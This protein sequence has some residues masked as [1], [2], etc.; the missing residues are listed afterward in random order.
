MKILFKNILRSFLKNKFQ[1]II[2]MILLVFGGFYFSLFCNTIMPITKAYS[3]DKVTSNIEQFRFYPTIEIPNQDMFDIAQKYNISQADLKSLSLEDLAA[4]YNIDT[5]S[6]SEENI[7]DLADNYKFSYEKYPYKLLTT[8]NKFYQITYY[9]GNINKN[10]FVEGNAP[11]QDEDIAI[12]VGFANENNI[13]LG[14]S[15]D[16]QNK[17]YKVCGFFYDLGNT[18]IYNSSKS[19]SIFVKNNAKLL[20]TNDS[21]KKIDADNKTIYFGKFAQ[22]PKNID[23]ELQ[24]MLESK[25]FLSLS[26]SSAISD[27]SMFDKTLT[28]QVSMMYLGSVVIL[29]IILIFIALFIGDHTKNSRKQ[30][31]ILLAM[32]YPKSK[33]LT[34]YVLFGMLMFFFVFTGTVLGFAC[35]DFIT[36]Q[37]AK[38][39]NYPVATD[40]INIR[41]MSIFSI[42]FTILISI[43]MLLRVRKQLSEKPLSLIS[44]GDL[45]KYGGFNIKMKKI[46]SCFPFKQR[47]RYNITLSN[48]PRFFIM[49]CCTSISAFLI[50]LAL[51]L[52]SGYSSG[53]SVYENKTSYEKVV[54]YNNVEKAD[55]DRYGS[56][57]LKTS[58]FLSQINDTNINKTIDIEFLDLNNS[59]LDFGQGEGAGVVVPLKYSYS[60]GVKIGDEVVIK[61]KNSSFKQKVL[62]FSPFTVNN[63]FYI[64]NNAIP[65]FD[66]TLSEYNYNGEYLKPGEEA[67]QKYNNVIT[68]ESLVEQIKT[69]QQNSSTLIVILVLFSIVTSFALIIIVSINNIGDN[70]KG[71]TM[72]LMSGY[73]KSTVS[74]L[75]LN[76]YSFAVVLGAGITL[77]GSSSLLYIITTLMNTSDIGFIQLRMNLIDTIATISIT[78]I[79]YCITLFVAKQ[80]YLK[81]NIREILNNE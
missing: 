45:T 58:A 50:L 66:E 32:G 37:L 63:T 22:T 24:R 51:S 38:V 36:L 62:A 78:V 73:K 74:S 40:V 8:D 44:N 71:I 29:A 28:S 17:S 18:N 12:S 16:I 75:L 60:F 6:Y 59:L 33:L 35:K 5:D 47:I 49:I 9:Q 15:L 21:F 30:Y 39:F 53:V 43:F 4:K 25:N 64:S 56:K 1:A 34:T 2:V 14:N 10:I 80:K 67:T 41:D 11:K 77:G 7:K 54:Y 72:L 23:L 48:L 57:F 46:I 81:G 55:K 42:A 76:I 68:K 19:L 20:I 52:F 65:K 69:M 79:I 27:V 13:K 61:T 26:P 70:I 3:N 31:G